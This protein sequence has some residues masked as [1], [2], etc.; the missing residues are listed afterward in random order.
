MLFN[1]I[2]SLSKIITQNLDKVDKIINMVDKFQTRIFFIAFILLFYFSSFPA[3]ASII[4][5]DKYISRQLSTSQNLPYNYVD[6]IYVDR[7]GFVWLSLYGG[8]LSMYNGSFF[9]SFST[10]SSQ[11]IS[12]NFVTKAQE[13][14]FGRL[15]ASSSAGISLIDIRTMTVLPV[16]QVIDS[17]VSNRFCNYI[18]IDTQDCLWFEAGGS[19]Y[20][21]SFTS[22]GDIDSLN[23]ICLKGSAQDDNN[24]YLVFKDLDCDGSVYVTAEGKLTKVVYD[25]SKKALKRITVSDSM[26]FGPDA[27]VL[28]LI[29]KENEIWI[30]SGNG[31]FRFDSNTG[32]WR[33]YR[34]DASDEKSL[35]HNKVTALCLTNDNTLLAGTLNGLNVY[36]PLEDNFD[37]Y[38]SEY[39][40]YGNKVLFNNFINCIHQIGDDIWIGT[41]IEGVTVLSKKGMNI[42]NIQHKPNDPYSFPNNPVKTLY[43]DRSGKL[44][45]CTVEGGISVQKKGRNS[46]VTYSGQNSN[47]PTNDITTFEQDNSDTVWAGTWGEGVCL[48]NVTGE[49]LQVH[50]VD[51]VNDGRFAKYINYLKFD[52]INNYMWIASLDGLACYDIT[53]GK[54]LDSP[55]LDDI[56]ECNDLFIDSQNNLWVGHQHG[57]RK[58]HLHSMQYAD[59]SG[60]SGVVSITEKND[61]TILAGTVRNGLFHLSADN[62]FEHVEIYLPTNRI[63]NVVPAGSSIWVFCA[64]GIVRIKDDFSTQSLSYSDGIPFFPSHKNAICKSA[65]GNICIGHQKGFSVIHQLNGEKTIHPS[66]IMLFQVSCSGKNRYAFNETEIDVHERD[67]NINLCFCDL[68]Y[69]LTNYA[70]YKYKFIG[71]KNEDWQNIN[72]TDKTIRLTSLKKGKYPLQIIKADANGHELCH[73]DLLLRVKPF[74]YKTVY[75]Y[76][77]LFGVLALLFMTEFHLRTKRLRQRQT[78]LEEEIQKHIGLLSKQ[79]IELEEKTTELYHQNQLLAKQNEELASQKILIQ[80]DVTHV[81]E[82]SDNNFRTKLIDTVMQLYK[83]P[84]L[85]SEMFCE[86]MNTSKSV[87][88]NKVKEVTGMPL[89]RFIR[90]F[91]LSVAKEILTHNTD[92]SKNIA[93][94]AYEVGFNDPKY[95][96][97]CFSNEYG[98]PPSESKIRG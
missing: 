32:D 27:R 16:P 18:A 94:V 62:V 2:L 69:E 10:E 26:I 98:F 55:V 74:F 15:W 58:V 70:T 45:L 42:T 7:T 92:E 82:S 41:E 29:K 19:L 24:L 40:D 33:L 9:T 21:C 67:K 51:D 84:N 31:L 48:I 47:L 34:N 22:Q 46:F 68:T 61:G 5:P 54:Y 35:S 44:W 17:L 78:E 25:D 8:G 83:N 36:N 96:T 52:S 50:L 12:S 76:I 56:K 63:L 80:Y 39:D 88:N 13:D 90:V 23:S 79:K 11:K 14:A 37:I 77:I 73:L 28:D 81:N 75:F 64:R 6:D 3:S 95:F 59:Y 91:R 93:D 49:H 89:G 97:R 38:N 66:R 86:A 71:T 53:H 30:A 65:D 60:L 72:A 20:R 43:Y 57:I 1:N 4:L 85:D 87:L